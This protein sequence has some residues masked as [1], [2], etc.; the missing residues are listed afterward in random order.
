VLKKWEI[1]KL[2]VHKTPEHISGKAP[3]LQR[4]SPNFAVNNIME[5]QKEEKLARNFRVPSGG[6]TQAKASKKAQVLALQ[7]RMRELEQKLTER[8]HELEKLHQETRSIVEARD[9]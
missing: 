6:S 8:D 1:N 2:F 3:I 5:R 4:R 7:E 9:K